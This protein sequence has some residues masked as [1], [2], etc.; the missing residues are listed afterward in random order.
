MQKAHP[1]GYADAASTTEALKH[2][3]IPV[4]F[5]HGTDDHFVPVEMTYE[6][7]KACTSEKRLLIVPGA[8]HCMS[9]LVG[10]STYERIAKEFGI[11]EQRKRIRRLSLKG[12]LSENSDN[13]I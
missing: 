3:Q 12:R 6:N 1:N 8:D 2:C 10:K 13:L 11:C 5:V 9:Y 7:Y 4:L